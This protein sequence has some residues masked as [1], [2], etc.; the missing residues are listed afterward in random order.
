MFLILATAFLDI[1]GL[2][3]FLPVFPSIIEGFGV[4]PSW[5]GYTQ[6]V[7]AIGMFIGGLF[8]GRLSDVYGR[9]KMLTYTSIINLAS[10]FIM[11]ISVWNL[12]LH[13]THSGTVHISEAWPI[14]FSHLK[15]VFQ[16]F[17]PVFILFLI[18]R[19]VGGLGGAGFGVIQAYISDISSPTDRMKNM[20]MMGAAFGTAFLIGPAIGGLLSQFASI[21]TTIMLCIAIIATNV[22]SIIFV[23]K[24]PKKHVHTEEIHLID[25]HFS[26]TVILLLGL[27]FGATLGFAAIQ[28]MSSQFYSDRFNF[29]PTQIGYTMAMVGIV[30]IIYQWAIV[31]HVRKHL[32]EMTMIRLAFLILT[33][34]F[35]GFGL[36]H[37][38]YY[39]FFWIALFPIGMGSFNPAIGSLLAQNAGK[40]MGKVMGYNTSIQSIGQ[41]FGPIIAGMLYV[42]PGSGIPFIASA[43]VFALLFFLAFWTKTKK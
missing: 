37:D 33:M 31:K 36:N 19:F 20:G 8:F 21:H 7:Y 39:L 12:V 22:L 3:I 18:A 2:S 11:L 6:A 23:L 10:Y 29:T 28:S 5:T 16:N 14:G 27:S 17:T 34:S 4:N 25:F 9:K 13:G 42:I 26:H 32:S 30:S 40:E 24:E 15:D 43:W 1:L 41:I 35:I 38:P